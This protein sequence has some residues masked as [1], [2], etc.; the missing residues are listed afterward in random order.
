MTR[1]ILRATLPAVAALAALLAVL[2]GARAFDDS[3]YPNWRGKWTRVP[4]P[5]VFG[6]ASFDPTKASG[7]RQQ[8][9]LTAEYQ[10]IFEENLAEQASG[11]HGR[12]RSHVCIPSGMPMI[13]TV[14][15]P[16]EALITE[17]T[18]HLAIQSFGIHRRVF[19]DGRDWP[20][21]VEPSYLGYS[22]GKWLDTDGDGRFDTLAIETRHMKGVRVFDPTGIP[23]HVDN[24]TV[25]KEVLYLDKENPNILRNDLTVID[26]A[27]THPWTVYKRYQRDPSP[28]PVWEEFVCEENNPHIVIGKD[29]YMLSADGLLMPSKKGQEPPDLRYFRQTRN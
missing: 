14:Y 10:K 28:Q 5:G 16:M 1:R 22:I 21:D 11:G 2:G 25:V 23:L 15:E 27:L 9:P 12:G 4:V 17:G 20:A 13:M 24:Q 7:P 18:T 3:N 29:D 6:V 19:T 26:H 8:A